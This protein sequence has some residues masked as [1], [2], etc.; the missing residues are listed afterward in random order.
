MHN[1]HILKSNHRVL[2]KNEVDTYGAPVF[3]ADYSMTVIAAQMCTN[4]NESMYI[5][6]L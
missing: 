4:P 1:S 2:Q 6:F 5:R 3:A